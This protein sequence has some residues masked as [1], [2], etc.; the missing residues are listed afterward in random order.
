MAPG[1]EYRRHPSKFTYDDLMKVVPKTE[2]VAW[3]EQAMDAAKGGA[4]LKGGKGIAAR[5]NW[6][7]GDQR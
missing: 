3:H 2:R 6:S 4:R 5:K 1:A 7:L